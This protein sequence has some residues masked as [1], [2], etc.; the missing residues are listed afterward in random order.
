[1][2]ANLNSFLDFL[3]SQSLYLTVLFVVIGVLA[4]LA[5]KQSAHLRYL[6][7][8]VVQV[9]QRLEGAKVLDAPSQV[10]KDGQWGKFN[11]SNDRPTGFHRVDIR[12]LP[13]LRGF[14][15]SCVLETD[16]EVSYL[17]EGDKQDN[18]GG[19]NLPIKVDCDM[20]PTLVV[21]A[22][23]SL[24]SFSNSMTYHS[25]LGETVD[26]SGRPASL[27]MII[28]PEI[29]EHKGMG[30]FGEK[31]KG[32]K[33]SPVDVNLPQIL[34]TADILLFPDE[35]TL[36]EVLNGI[37]S[38]GLQQHV[39]RGEKG[40]IPMVPMEIG[41]A[42]TEFK[43]EIKQLQEV[44]RRNA[45]IHVLSTPAVVVSI[46]KPAELF[47]GQ[48]IVTGQPAEDQSPFGGVKIH[49]LPKDILPDDKCKMNI[50][51]EVSSIDKV[52]QGN[53]PVISTRKIHTS[54]TLSSDQ[55]LLF[56][57]GSITYRS[58]SVANTDP[59]ATASLLILV[60]FEIIHSH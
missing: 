50:D 30:V 22:H 20:T 32:T 53:L 35:S 29:I 3:V 17:I 15:Q 33:R 54:N 42:W 40:D 47:V 36:Q 38:T 44:V 56:P 25:L 28:T 6:L 41:G 27:L 46:G 2:H 9:V 13:H 58:L 57:S 60:K 21:P 10:V 45:G 39:I 7:W 37:G 18:Q 43:N 52:K 34:V 24:L 1:M 8:L 31:T 26:G 12:V 14:D 55:Q 16:A 23:H 51:V 11:L 49:V 19:P 48:K 59:N 4:I 5:R